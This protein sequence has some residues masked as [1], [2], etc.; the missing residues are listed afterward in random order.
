MAG[1]FDDVP[2]PPP[3]A[4]PS[5]TG[6]FDTVGQPPTPEERSTINRAA[7]YAGSVAADIGRGTI[8]APIE[9]AQ[10]IFELGSA[11]ADYALGTDL[12]DDVTEA[13]DSVQDWLGTNPKGATGYVT[14]EIMGFGLGFIPVAG[15]LGRANSVARATKAGRAVNVAYN[16]SRY[17][18]SATA[19]GKSAAGQA[20]LGNRLKLMLTTGAGYGAYG[21][22]FSP[23]GRVTLSD[24]VDW[25]PDA[26]RTEDI[27][28][29]KSRERAAAMFRNKFRLGAEDASLG[30]A[31][32]FGI[33][34]I[35]KGLQAAAPAV[36]SGVNRLKSSAGAQ[37]VDNALQAIGDTKTMQTAKAKFDRYIRPSKGIDPVLYQELVD[38][39]SYTRG[40]K[41]IAQNSLS[42]LDELAVDFNKQ[43]GVRGNVGARSPSVLHD[44]LRLYLH[45]VNDALDGLP[46]GAKRV[47]ESMEREYARYTNDLMVE[48]EQVVDAT[49]PG[50][51]QHVKAKAA[52]NEFKRNA[53]RG[54]RTLRRS[55]DIHMRPVDFYKNFDAANPKIDEAVEE[56]SRN[57]ISL[58]QNNAVMKEVFGE[59]STPEVFGR[60][61]DTPE[62]RAEL[63]PVSRRIVM[64]SLGLE[65][66]NAGVPI[67]KAIEN[68]LKALKEIQSRGT[69]TTRVAQRNSL[70]REKEGLFIKR[71]E[72]LD[73]TPALRQL[74]GEV[75]DIRD[76]YVYTIDSLASAAAKLRFFNNMRLSGYT[77]DFLTGID[78]V[79]NG[80]RPIAV[81]PALSDMATNTR[82]ID[83]AAVEGEAFQLGQIA[84]DLSVQRSVP[85][86]TD[87]VLQQ[88][89]TMLRESGY[90]QLGED[91]AEETSSVMGGQF[92]TMT[93]AWVPREV[94]QALTTA[95]SPFGFGG[96]SAVAMA[97]SMANAANGLVQRATVIL[98]PF[99]R[100]RDMIGTFNFIGATGNLLREMDVAGQ[101]QLMLH[102]Y[103]DLADDGVRRMRMKSEL[104]DIVDTNV[105]LR[106]INRYQELGIDYGTPSVVRAAQKVNKGFTELPLVGKLVSAANGGLERTAELTDILGKQIVLAGEEQKLAT[107]YRAAKVNLM[108]EEVAAALM[109][110][111]V[112]GRISSQMF[113]DLSPVEVAA[114]QNVRNLMPNYGKISE[115]VRTFFERVPF[116]GNFTSF[117]IETLRVSHNVVNQ[118]MKELTFTMNDATRAYVDAT[119]GAGS[120]A[121]FQDG[122]RGIGMHRITSFAAYAGAAPKAIS[123]ASMKATGTSQEELEAAR[124]LGPD[125]LAGT[126]LLVVEKDN[127]GRIEV[128]NLNQILPYSFAY[129]GAQAAL[130]SFHKGELDRGMVERITG[131]MAQGAW[132][133]GETFFGDTILFERI[134]DLAKRG[135][136]TSTGREIWTGG[137][138]HDLDDWF[139]RGK[140]GLAHL[141]DA[142]VPGWMKL[143]ATGE[144]GQVRAGNIVRG[145]LDMPGPTLSRNRDPSLME[146]FGK[147]VTGASPIQIDALQAGQ[148]RAEEY[149]QDRS[150]ERRVAAREIARPGATRRSITA[151]WNKYLDQLGEDQAR[152]HQ[153]VQNMR[154]LGLDDRQVRVAMQEIAEEGTREINTI[155]QGKFYPGLVSPE[156]VSRL[157]R[158]VREEYNLRQVPIEVIQD[159]QRLSRDRIGEDLSSFLPGETPRFVRNDMPSTGLFDNVMRPGASAPAP[160]STGL[161]DSMAP[162]AA[163]SFGDLGS[164]APAVS[165]R[166]TPRPSDL[167]GGTLEEQMRNSE[168]NR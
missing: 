71:K 36:G 37:A 61:I 15:W 45:G 155:M 28:Q 158:M 35:G 106:L 154:T 140:Q 152:L 9:L 133:Y 41:S 55:F 18:R 131:A 8:N 120:A 113:E 26:M 72:I 121:R 64:D 156:S 17:M 53:G 98:N 104:A 1:L 73:V 101:F 68:K 151:A 112:Y 49:L 86:S 168:I 47:A 145:A 118:G 132:A 70:L 93:G 34:G 136:E 94:H 57:I 39:Q 111:G 100:V 80:Q 43:A 78:K 32:D 122:I 31:V 109:D 117:A 52:F 76:T 91:I 10:G 135:G 79:R 162:A 102:S 63:R 103:A 56:V 99:S 30:L 105:M 167:L 58:R 82:T 48:L 161:F 29:L 125:Y 139:T 127:N 81:S 42:R 85:M 148:Y 157:R 166:P 25:L 92:A 3:A 14:Q 67:E 147:F 11:A 40:A 12:S 74:M 2:G 69:G 143:F 124:A 23:E 87:E 33:L 129:E 21:F 126:D 119:Y 163:P 59:M 75:T 142:F 13:F 88:Y 165:G 153:R 97:T 128:I 141:G 51:P 77:D 108:D 115:G 114:A 6:L 123:Y 89:N 110:G 138:P 84:D 27:S 107:V 19:F 16:S 4:A 44:R 65:A 38:A 150:A 62:I 46:S 134:W 5:G 164:G 50:T 160:A 130:Q 54:S 96:H 137:K 146:E 149:A 95:A 60:L 20:L 7:R 22:A 116:V 66:V 144:G 159:L 24:S 90:V 83:P